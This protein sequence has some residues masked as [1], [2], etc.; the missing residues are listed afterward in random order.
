MVLLRYPV[1]KDQARDGALLTSPT[2]KLKS[3][4]QR[5]KIGCGAH[6]DC[7]FMTILATDT[8]P[9]LQVRVNHQRVIQRVGLNNRRAMWIAI[10]R[11]GASTLCVESEEKQNAH[12]TTTP[13]HTTPYTTPHTTTPQ[14][15][16]AD[17]KSGANGDGWIDVPVVGEC[18]P[19]YPFK[20][21]EGGVG[22]GDGSGGGSDS[23]GGG[24]GG[25]G[26]AG[27][28]GESPSADYAFVVNLGDMAERWSND[29]YKSTWHRVHLYD[30]DAE[31]DGGGPET[32]STGS[33]GRAGSAGSAGSSNTAPAP[34]R[35][36]IPFFCNCNF[37]TPIDG[38]DLLAATDVG[39]D[40]STTAGA[41]GGAQGVHHEPTTA[42]KYIMEKLGLMRT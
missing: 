14:V 39:G 25:S 29:R 42:G 27:D 31:K 33:T 2:K 19:E 10:V 28:A 13:S 5:H 40:A 34:A 17:G 30:E 7:G 20:S 37:D 21:P 9:G 18:G 4:S 23:V 3:D 12:G 38:R 16:H 1:R 8:I 24:A 32:G 36:S 22:G 41:A 15:Q 26:G 6:T 35:Y 11:V